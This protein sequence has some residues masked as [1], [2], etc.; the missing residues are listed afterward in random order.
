[1]RILVLGASGMLGHAIIRI[2]NEIEA[3]E[4]FGTVRT[5]KIKKYFSS[6]IASR[7]IVNHDITIDS[8]VEKIFKK[9]NPQV[10]I[11]CVSLSK[12]LL[13]SADPL[14]MIPLYALL[15]HRLSKFCKDIDARFINISSDAVF[16]GEKGGYSEQDPSDANDIYGNT[17]FLGETHED[18]TI[19]IRTSIIGHELESNNGL[20][21]WFLLQKKQCECFSNAIFSGLPTVIL[22]QIIRDVVVPQPNLYGIYH[23]AA[24][25]ISKCDLL[26]LIAKV[27]EISID[28][29]SNDKLHIDR[30]LNTNLF[31]QETGYTPPNWEQLIKVM[32]SYNKLV[33]N[34]NLM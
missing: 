14:L 24:E 18:H 2:F 30:S 21:E 8:N 15:P 31:E 5:E 3:F 10:V 27:Y 28:F 13:R 29:I 12:Q 4:V 6:S 22:A 7:L 1:M 16:S 17:K 25:P 20:V 19:T 26:K 23:I 11:N 9:V 32:Y 33:K 34:R